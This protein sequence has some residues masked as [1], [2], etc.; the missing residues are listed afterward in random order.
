MRRIADVKLTRRARVVGIAGL[1]ALALAG[2]GFVVASGSSASTGEVE[3]G[4]LLPDKAS[5]ARWEAA[6]KPALQAAFAKAGVSASVRN[7]EGDPTT[8]QQQAQE[9]MIAGAKVLLLV[10]LDTNASA[11]IAT[12]AHARGVKVVHYDRFGPGAGSDAYVSFD[13]RRVGQLQGE[14]LLSCLK[15]KGVSKPRIALVHGS[16]DDNNA[17]QF[18]EGY[19]GVV[20]PLFAKGSAV[21]VASEAVPGWVPAKGKTIF[22]KMLRDSGGKIDAVLAANDGLGNAVIEHLREE[23]AGPLPVTGQDFTLEAVRNILSGEQCMTVFKDAKKEADAAAKLAI[24]YA[25]GEEPGDLLNGET[26]DGSRSVPSAL[27]TPEA[28][29]ADNVKELAFGAGGFKREEVCEGE[30]AAVCEKAGV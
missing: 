16:P 8:Q 21:E 23:K 24:A 14:A 18:A 19:R 11:A 9:A 2:G 15:A 6:D 17:T 25:R 4:V 7:A 27:L 26:K 3:I 28:V 10:G 22:A 12:V 13:N 30:W 1:G 29:T 20:D 5:S